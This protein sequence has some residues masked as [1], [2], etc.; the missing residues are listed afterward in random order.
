MFP[1]KKYTAKR[2]EISH[3][4]LYLFLKKIKEWTTYETFRR[5]HRI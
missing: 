5:N 2:D 1:F 3:I 4:V